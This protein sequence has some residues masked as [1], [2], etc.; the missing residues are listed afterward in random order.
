MSQLLLRFFISLFS[1]LFFSLSLFFS[2]LKGLTRNALFCS[3][4]SV[5]VSRIVFLWCDFYPKSWNPNSIPV[6]LWRCT[7]RKQ[8]TNQSSG[9]SNWRPKLAFRNDWKSLYKWFRREIFRKKICFD[10]KVYL[11]REAVGI[12]NFRSCADWNLDRQSFF[13]VFFCSKIIL[14]F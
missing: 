2:L 1:I 6:R 3:C 13:L 11:G 7:K 8:S 9:Q 14:N 4:F 5:C 12:T 10:K